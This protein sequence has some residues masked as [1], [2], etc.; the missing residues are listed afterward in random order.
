MHDLHGRGQTTGVAATARRPMRCHDEE[1]AESLALAQQG[2][3]D[4]VCHAR[5][6]SYNFV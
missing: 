2:I 6:H 5:R 4:G 3:P 1:A